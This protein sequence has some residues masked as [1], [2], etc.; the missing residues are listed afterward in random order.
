MQNFAQRLARHIERDPQT[1]EQRETGWGD[2]TTNRATECNTLDDK[3][4]RVIT[5]ELML[6][7]DQEYNISK[8]PKQHSIGGASSG[9]IAAFTVAR[10]RPNHFHRF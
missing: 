10:E 3:Y 9:A 8:D 7:L 4:A 2:G 5:E 6:V 1:S